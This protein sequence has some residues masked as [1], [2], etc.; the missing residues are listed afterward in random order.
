M[1][2]AIEDA[3][4]DSSEDTP[5]GVPWGLYK[6]ARQGAFGG[7][8]K[9]ALSCLRQFWT[10]ETPL[11]IIKKYFLFHLRALSFSKY[12]SFFLDFLVT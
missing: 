2:S 8:I 9:G 1:V 12:L 11:K 7:E 10:T 3:T 5:K 6:D 4:E